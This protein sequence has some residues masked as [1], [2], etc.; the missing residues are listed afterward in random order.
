[1]DMGSYPEVYLCDRIEAEAIKGIDE[2]SE[3]HPV[4]RRE[5]EY[6]E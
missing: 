3:F 4:S 2:H 1:M 6:L 5:F